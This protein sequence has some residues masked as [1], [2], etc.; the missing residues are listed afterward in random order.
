M[1]K[2]IVLCSSL[3]LIGCQIEQVER[4]SIKNYT[5]TDE[6]LTMVERDFEIC[7]RSSYMSS[8]CFLSAKKAYCV[9]TNEEETND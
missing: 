7:N 3:L 6:Q 2:V 9:K 5:C 8:H 4:D 1:H